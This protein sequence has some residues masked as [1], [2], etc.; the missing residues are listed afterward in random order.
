M[1][2]N[3]TLTLDSTIL[4]NNTSNNAGN[5]LAIPFG[6]FTVT[7]CLVEDATGFTLPGSVTGNDPQLAPLGLY[8]SMTR[9]HI[10]LQGSPAID[11]GQNTLA[12]LTDQRGLSFERTV[13]AT[14]EQKTDIGAVEFQ[15]PAVVSVVS[16]AEHLGESTPSTSRIT[17]LVITFNQAVT[18][19]AN[20]QDAFALVRTGPATG[21][22]RESTTC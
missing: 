21:R 7:K 11:Q 6:T 14:V 16:Y 20:P 2:S 18:L 15:E 3:G 12:L 17:S 9:T 8:G 1:C 10:V 5:D 22:R 4:A 13:S 19:P